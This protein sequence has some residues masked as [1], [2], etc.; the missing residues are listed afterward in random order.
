[1]AAGEGRP[2]CD[3]GVLC[4]KLPIYPLGKLINFGDKV[5]MRYLPFQTEISFYLQEFP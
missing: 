1:M 4:F 5:Q 2:I 3:L